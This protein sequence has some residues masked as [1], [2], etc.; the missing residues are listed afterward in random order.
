MQKSKLTIGAAGAAL[1]LA[2]LG[3]WMLSGG[4]REIGRAHV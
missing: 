2:G 1:G 4:Q 3:A